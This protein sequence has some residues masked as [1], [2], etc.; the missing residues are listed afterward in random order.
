MK[1]LLRAM[2]KQ[3]T[4]PRLVLLS[5]LLGFL[6]LGL[7]LSPSPASAEDPT[8]RLAVLEL[9][10]A[11]ERDTLSAFSDQVRQAALRS[12]K[13]TSYEV[14]T[15][16][17]MAMLARNVGIDLAACQEGAECQVD[18]G[19]K[20]G[21]TLVLSGSVTKA[22]SF[23]VA[24]L[25]LHGTVAGRLLSSSAAKAT[26]EISMLDELSREAAELL[27]SSTRSRELRPHMIDRIIRNNAAI[28]SC[29]RAEEAL[30]PEMDRQKIYLRFEILP[31]GGVT[32]SGITTERWRGTRLDRCISGE[33]SKLKFPSFEGNKKKVTYPLY[34]N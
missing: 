28:L 14:M 24:T 10:G 1:R 22:G 23:L 30:A 5:S 17:N 4:R 20:V 8:K 29:V 33:L 26:D 27:R 34:I 11:F 6:L 7:L 19:R 31:D 12:L 9:T 18:I 32:P 3:G 21:A 15:R 16:E 13:G 25:K 2:V